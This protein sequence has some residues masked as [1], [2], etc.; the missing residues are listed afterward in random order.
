[1]AGLGVGQGYGNQ[2]IEDAQQENT[3]RE[4]CG[5]NLDAVRFFSIF[6]PL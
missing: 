5:R 1:M 3:P 2:E 6:L 4:M